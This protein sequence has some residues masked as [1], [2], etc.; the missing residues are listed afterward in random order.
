MRA[1][2]TVLRDADGPFTVEEVELAPPGPGEALVR[3]ADTGLCHTVIEGAD[4]DVAARIT[5]WTGGVDRALDTTGVPSVVASA[6]ESLR[7]RGVCGLVGTG[8]DI[9]LPSRLMVSG[10]TVKYLME[11]DAV[12]QR[13]IPRLIDLW[14]QGRFPFDR[15]IRTY[16]LDAVNDAERDTAG[17]ETVKAVLLPGELST[18]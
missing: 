14:Q 9:T 10:V 7:T 8:G 11:G 6:L 18:V 2:A 15:L 16:A 5:G 1:H 4:P 17:G 3:I 12:P 13:F